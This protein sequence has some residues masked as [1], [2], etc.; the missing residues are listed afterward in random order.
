MQA[1]WERAAAKGSYRR[2]RSQALGGAIATSAMDG[3]LRGGV[4]IWRTHI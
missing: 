4:G 2:Q 3:T 1:M